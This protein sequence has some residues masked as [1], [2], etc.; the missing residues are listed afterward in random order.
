M[1]EHLVDRAFHAQRVEYEYPQH[2]ESHMRNRGISHE[3]FQVRLHHGHE[4]AV[5]NSDEGERT[6]DRSKLPR[7]VREKRLAETQHAVSSHLKEDSGQ[8][9]GACRGRLNVRVGQP[10]VK[11]KERNL[12]GECYKECK[13][14]PALLL[15]REQRSRAQVVQH[16][17]K[18][19]T[20]REVV[21]VEN[22]REHQ[23]RAHHR[24]QD[25]LDRGINAALVTPN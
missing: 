16:M 21:K 9:N 20:A 24:V 3:L 14:K 11:R 5:N 4:V 23:G 15:H 7:R 12:N 19:K 6:N 1:A 18:I 8:E 25:K 13:E 10:R 17:G 22:P 2:T